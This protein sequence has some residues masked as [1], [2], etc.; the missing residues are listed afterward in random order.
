[1]NFLAIAMV[2]FFLPRGKVVALSILLAELGLA[3]YVYMPIVSELR[4]PLPM[5]W[6]YPRTWEG[7]VH[8]I[9]RGQYD[10]TPFHNPFTMRF[11]RQV[12][13]YLADLRGQFTLPIVMLGFLPFTAWE[14]KIAG[15]R[16]RAMHVAIVL[17]ILIFAIVFAEEV[18]LPTGIPAFT[19][20]YK[21]MVAGILLLLGVGSALILVEE[22]IE[23]FDRV[24]GKGEA[25]TPEK[26]VDF[27]TL[28]SVLGAY[29]V[30]VVTLVMKMTEV[31][32]PLWMSENEEAASSAGEII[33]RAIGLGALV[34]LPFMVVAL[35]WALV[36]GKHEARIS[37]DSISRKW[38]ITTMFG[39]LALGIVFINLANLQMDIQ[40]TIVQKVKF[41]SSHALFSF[42]IGYGLV[43]GL[44]AVENV[45]RKSMLIK[46]MSLITAVL[47]VTI[48][49][50]Q[51]AYSREL[52]KIFGGSEQAGHDFG[53]QF[54]NYQ[55]RGAEAILEE[56]DPEEEPPPDPT[57]PPAMEHKAVFF[58]GTDPGRFVPTYMIYSADVR[59]DIYLITQN[60]LADPTYLSIMRDLYGNEIWMPSKTESQIAFQRYVQEVKAG[61]RPRNAE[62]KLDGDRVQI[63]GAFGVMEINGIV[64]QMIFERNNYRTAFYVEES[65]VIRW[66][67]DYMEPHGLILKVNKEKGAVKPETV[68]ADM[69]FWDWYT[70]RLTGNPKYKRDVFA[71]KSFS[72]LRTA[73]A[74]YYENRNMFD[75]AERAFHEAR[76]LYPL[77][78]EASFRLAK[79]VLMTIGE[80]DYARQVVSDFGERDPG[81]DKTA[82]FIDDLDRY[83]KMRDRI[84]EIEKRPVDLQLALELS[85]LYLAVGMTNKLVALASQTLQRNDLPAPFYFQLA[86]R[87]IQVRSMSLAEKALEMCTSMMETNAPPEN[88]LGVIE[89]YSRLGNNVKVEELLT[90]YLQARPENWSA[91]L[92]L[93]AVRTILQDVKGAD[94]ALKKGITMGGAQAIAVINQEP[95]F[96]QYRNKAK[97]YFR[98]LGR[99]PGLGPLR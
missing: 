58:G 27:L 63:Q 25:T 57:Y 64:A 70:R 20:V 51:N 41:I 68:T 67:Y 48:P 32:K 92:N 87:M 2:Y 99:V 37:I 66:M 90:Q 31:L 84:T 35:L 97:E 18:I 79:D 23:M 6:G 15:R 28:I 1:M 89:M 73:I 17:S 47:L 40:D 93:C 59:P 80:F 3:Y 5:N 65:Y 11:V 49:I 10:K 42:W 9:T 61:I 62:I 43:L 55:L 22:G 96:T 12:G 46:V 50:Q 76:I 30:Y 81:C 74:G 85:D 29:A 4:R 54:G 75:V 56:M 95:I 53:W 52:I 39:F 36:R 8:A 82:M 77:S 33:L 44:A 26:I 45:F 38:I 19:F 86:Q 88:M 34:I 7:F 91:W 71:K 83:K 21:F 13:F 78:P 14:L 60:A 69:D 98:E 24:A 94:E 16:I 72:K